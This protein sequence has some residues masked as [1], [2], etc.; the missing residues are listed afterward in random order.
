MSNT[1]DYETLLPIITAIPDDEVRSPAIP[2]EDYAKE[3][4]HLHSWCQ[5]DKEALTARALDWDIVT[6]IPL[7]VGALR[8]A[9]SR[10]EH[11]RFDHGELGRTWKKE[12]DHG[13]YFRDFLLREFRYAYDNDPVLLSK[14]SRIADGDGHADMIQ[15]LNDLAVLGREYAEPLQAT[16]FDLAHLDRAAHLSDKLGS[17]QADAQVS[18]EQ[19]SDALVIRNRSYT[20]L[21]QAIDAVRKLGQLV[22]FG[23]DDRLKGYHSQY[24][25]KYRSNSSSEQP[26]ETGPQ[27]KSTD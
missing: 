20:Y 23:D 16:R 3:G 10:W 19:N 8:E 22:F 7:R 12:S 24:Y 2:V 9:N 11:Q 5:K 6:S 15:D 27:S 17:M 26:D 21:K 25:R 18:R 4:E 1:E 14:V 13:Y